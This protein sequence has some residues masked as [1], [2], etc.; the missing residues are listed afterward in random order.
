MRGCGAY[1]AVMM[2]SVTTPDI[3]KSILSFTAAFK[4]MPI[5]AFLFCSV[6]QRT[7][8]W[9]PAWLILCLPLSPPIRLLNIRSGV[10]VNIADLPPGSSVFV[11]AVCWQPNH[12]VRRKERLSNFCLLCRVLFRIFFFFLL[13]FFPLPVDSVDW[14]S[15]CKT[16]LSKWRWGKSKVTVALEVF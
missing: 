9:S 8:R 1:A 4:G 3:V 2:W 15:V 11:S 13:E 7:E 14:T 12:A 16:T 6:P 10:V 5:Y